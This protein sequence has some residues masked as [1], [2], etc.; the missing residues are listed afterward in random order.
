LPSCLLTSSGFQVAQ[1]KDDSILVRQAAQFLVKQWPEI[2]PEITVLNGWFWHRRYLPFSDFLLGDG[3]SG[4]QRRLMCHAVEPVS[5]H[6]SRY[7]GSC[8]LNQNK[9]SSLK[10][11]FRIV[12]MEQAAANAPDH[13]AMLANQGRK[14]RFVSAIYKASQQLS[15]G[16]P[17][18]VFQEH[19]GRPS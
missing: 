7:H 11:V 18:F 12:L 4:F 16:W 3:S 14:S 1:D 8:F 10:S 6:L 9:K 19:G 2:V 15:I 17:R 13:R 5:D